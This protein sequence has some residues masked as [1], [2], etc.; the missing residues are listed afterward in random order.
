MQPVRATVARAILAVVTLVLLI[1]QI[2]FALVPLLAPDH[3]WAARRSSIVGRWLW[4][5][6]P[7]FLGVGALAWAAIYVPAGE[8]KPAIWLVP[9]VALA[10]SWIALRQVAGPPPA[11]HAR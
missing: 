11:R 10:V 8:L 7:A 9:A 4:T 1:S 5:L 2:G 3:I 6:V